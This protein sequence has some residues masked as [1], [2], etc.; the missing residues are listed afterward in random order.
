M[1]T[2]RDQPDSILH[3]YRRLLALRR[4]TPALRWGAWL[5]VSGSPDLFAWWRTIETPGTPEATDEWF[6][7]VNPTDDRQ[8]VSGGNADVAGVTVVASTDTALEGTPLGHDLP[9]RVALIARRSGSM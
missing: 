8:R 7:Y 5:P 3:W 4:A 6:V 9:A 2:Q 1:A